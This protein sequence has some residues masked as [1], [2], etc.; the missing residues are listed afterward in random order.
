MRVLTTIPIKEDAVKRFIAQHADKI[1]GVLSGFDRL[2]FRG[3]LLGLVHVEGFQLFLNVAGVLRKHFRAFL[4]KATAQLQDASL[5]VARETRRPVTYLPSSQTDKEAHVRDTAAKDKITEGL[6]EVLTCVEPCTSFQIFRNRETKRTEVRRHW[7]RCKHIYQYWIDPVFG[8][9]HARLQT[10][11]PFSL[12]IYVNGREWLARQMD[13]AGIAYERRDNCFVRIDDLAAAQ[14]LAEEQRKTPWHRELSRIARLAHPALP[15]ILGPFRADYYWSLWQSEWATDVM[16]RTPQELAGIY[17]P[18]IHH[19]ITSFGSADVMRFLGGKVHGNFA[20]EIVSD[21]KHRPEGIRIKHSV[22][23]N[24]VK[25][26]DKQGS[27]LRV[28]TTINDSAGIKVF[29]AK[30]GD[31]QGP[32]AWRG[33]RQG[34]ADLPRR[35]KVSQASNE[36]YLDALAS[37]DTSTRLGDLIQGVV[38]PKL[39]NGTRTRGLRPWTPED[40]ALIQAANRA[41]FC[42]NGFRN[43][44]LVAKLFPQPSADPAERRRRSA[45][46]TRLIRLLRVHGL[47]RKQSG[48]FRYLVTPKGRDLFTAVL[49]AQQLSLAQLKVP[50]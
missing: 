2:L 23:S 18:L 6:I 25:A 47:I 14:R 38:H 4:T 1:I 37:A 43:R 29:R 19:G 34:I 49:A 27:V 40:L 48:S 46:V 21:F 36:R 45:R 35:A 20:G 26:Y 16:F 41:E 15:D 28:E 22:G 42:V 9:M 10:W 13:R 44:D 30:Q 17:R 3:T 39:E 5:R 8:F 31:P 24:S 33:I 11:F 50:A 12:Q 7:T 32:K